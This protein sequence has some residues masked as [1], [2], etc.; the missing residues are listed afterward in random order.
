MIYPAGG[1]TS[2][3]ERNASGRHRAFTLVE[4]LVVIGIIALL[5]AILLP[6]LAIA[7]R[8]ALRTSCSAKLHTIMTAA[9]LHRD[10]HQDY[11]PLAG[12]VPG[13]TPETLDDTYAK[14]Y[15]YFSA[16]TGLA[17]RQLCPI[18]TSLETQMS[19]SSV[20]FS[21][22]GI[23][24]VSGETGRESAMLDPRG[25]TKYF[26][27]PAQADS[28]KDILPQYVFMY[29]SYGGGVS[30]MEPQSYMFNEYVLGWQDTYGH[31]RGKASLIH[32]PAITFFAA[33][34][35]GGSTLVNHEGTGLPNGL[36]TLYNMTTQVPVSVADAFNAP[37]MGGG[38]AGDH[39]NF[40]LK[41]HDNKI[42]IAFCDGHVET[43]N[44]TG[45]DLGN[46]WIK[47]P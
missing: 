38:N 4:L 18:S 37:L 5:I 2:W 47:A 15:D 29:A 32:N 13:T 46:V 33:D 16:T 10:S 26:V 28:P 36:Y 40:D 1:K 12:L 7:R 24:G 9:E 34:G 44:L 22:T 25:L 30:L 21:Q 14:K 39:Q 23:L 20:I 6:S 42:N 35:L 41:R 3:A 27:C 43:R 45:N 19:K 11:Y 31:L 17:A 8:Q